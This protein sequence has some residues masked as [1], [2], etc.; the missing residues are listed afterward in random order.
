MQ[1]GWHRFFAD[2]F[3]CDKRAGRAL[4]ALSVCQLYVSCPLGKDTLCLESP[5]QRMGSIAGKGNSAL[6]SACRG[7]LKGKE[8]GF[9]H[10][11]LLLPFSP[12]VEAFP[13]L[14]HKGRRNLKWTGCR[15][16]GCG[17]NCPPAVHTKNVC[18][19]AENGRGQRTAGPLPYRQGDLSRP[20]TIGK[21]SFHMITL[22]NIIAF[23]GW[24]G[25]LWA[26][27]CSWPD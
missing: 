5:F 20:Q 7:L 1:R 14:M 18:P 6:R 17:H 23:G 15:L 2:I 3:Q 16:V 8:T 27:S 25:C 4:A 22:S 21:D 12:F 19:N 10:T 9:L 24:Q 26:W 13:A 11:F